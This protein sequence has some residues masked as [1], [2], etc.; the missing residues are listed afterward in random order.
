MNYKHLLLIIFLVLNSC[1]EYIV[2]E[3]Y[4][5]ITSISKSFFLNKGFALVYEESLFNDKIVKDKIDPRSLLIFQ[6]NLKQN[7]T[8]KITNLIN[9]KTI[10]AKVGK[11]TLYPNF[12]NSVISKRIAKELNI[13]KLETY[14][15]IKEIVE[16]SSFVAKKAKMYDEEKRVATKVPI[17]EI[18]IKNLSSD[19]STENKTKKVMFNYI[20]KIADFYFKTSADQMKSRIL[21]ETVIKKVN[22]NKITKQKFRVYLGPYSNLNSL[23]KS[24]NAI[25]VLNFDNIEIIKQ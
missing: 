22:I 2:K 11:K 12:Y 8:V 19:I 7:S 20:I 18:Q 13:N 14:I 4:K 24:F 5:P 1:A 25:N 3:D 10:I 6:K 9:S 23:K 15:E 17:D 21:N 16:N